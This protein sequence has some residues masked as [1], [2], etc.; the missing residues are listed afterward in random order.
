ML[1]CRSLKKYKKIALN[2][3]FFSVRYHPITFPLTCR[4]SSRRDKNVFAG[5]LNIEQTEIIL[6]PFYLY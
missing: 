4:V 5:F 6:N 2:T 3:F 1:H